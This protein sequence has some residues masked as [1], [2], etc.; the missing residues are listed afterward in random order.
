MGL[1]NCCKKRSPIN[2][3]N[4]D[5]DNQSNTNIKHISNSK[6]KKENN[7]NIFIVNDDDNNIRSDSITNAEKQF[8]E[9]TNSIK[10]GL[11]NIGATCYMNATLQSL[12]NTKSLNNYF[13][14][15][16]NYKKNDASKKLSNQFYLVLENL[17]NKKKNGKSYSPNKFKELI[18]E[19]NPLFK[20]VQANDS[21]DLINLII[22]QIHEEL[23]IIQQD[24][25]NNNNNEDNIA[26]ANIQT[27]PKKLFDIFYNN[28]KK[29]FNSIISD[30]FYGITQT[31]TICQ[32]CRVVKYNYEIMYF[33]EFPLE[34]VNIY[35][36]KTPI[37]INYQMQ[38]P[39]IDIYECF[40]F[41]QKGEL[42]T[43]D[44][45]MYCD[46]CHITCDAFYISKLYKPPKYFI[47]ILNRGKNNIY[48]CN[49][50][51]PEI[52]NLSPYVVG[53]EANTMFDLYAV[54]CHFGP[55]SMGGHFIAYC[56]NALNDK[57]YCYNDSTVTLCQEKNYL[58][59]V[60]YIL[61]YQVIDV[62]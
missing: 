62:A 42:M 41:Y 9:D 57:W 54:I 28:Y 13:L 47:L 11:D 30:T 48:Q 14:H 46:L 4:L 34:Q 19:M 17:W 26:I 35:F 61:F 12:S 25:I 38:Q 1:V 5:I 6:M 2:I 39:D 10:I 27:D 24:N 32:N 15:N 37:Q 49:V 52:L 44:N 45:A 16:Y 31:E 50:T 51:F 55:S 7:N 23:N 53:K 60:P 8:K 33:L 36:G 29:N 43:K 3:K 58:T 59:G 21:K 20:G 22:G 40:K 56:R 18:S